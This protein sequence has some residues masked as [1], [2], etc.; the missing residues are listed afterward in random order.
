MRKIDLI[1]L[2]VVALLQRRTRTAL[3]LLGIVVGACLLVTSL[4]AFRGVHIAIENQ[5]AGSERMQRIHVT[6]KYGDHEEAVAK[7]VVEGNVSD[8]RRTRLKKEIAR[9]APGHERKPTQPITRDL[10]AQLAEIEHVDYVWPNMQRYWQFYWDEQEEHGQTMAA[11]TGPQGVEHL[12]VAGRGFKSD[13][14]KAV[15][16]H[17]YFVYEYFVYEYFVYDWGFQDDSLVEEFLGEKIRIEN[18]TQRKHAISFFDSFSGSEFTVTEKALLGSLLVRFPD[19]IDQFEVSADSK[20]LLKRAFTVA[21]EEDEEQIAISEEYN[22]VG[23][24]R[25]PTEDERNGMP[26]GWQ[27][28]NTALV[29]PVQTAIE[30]NSKLSGQEQFWIDGA[31]V[32]A[33]ANETV[34]DVVE[35]LEVTGVQTHSMVVFLEHVLRN[36]ALIM[37]GMTGFAAAA[38]LVAAIGIT[39]YDGDGRAGEN[40]RDRHHESCRGQRRSDHEHL[41]D[42][43]PAARTCWRITGSA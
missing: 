12:I 42:R 20:A 24:F 14:E 35:S 16:V 34:R 38:L 4:A 23:I 36:L 13:D 2:A 7:A 3:T 25:S 17:E 29:L 10:L 5:F 31:T 32:K 40:P 15:L 8:E 30:L 39:N 22:V 11:I 9:H 1:G 28:N 18:Y 6:T 41:P 33:D 27:W 21:P 19:L 43:R 26:F 37:C